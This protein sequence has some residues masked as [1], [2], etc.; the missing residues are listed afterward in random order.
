[1]FF[2]LAGRPPFADGSMVQKLLQ[3]QQEP[4]PAI[5][6]VRSDVPRSFAAIL[7]RLMEKNPA[8]RYQRPAE[9]VADLLA[10][11]D[12]HGHVV[13]AQRS[14]TATLEPSVP[15]R[16][17]ARLPWLVP[18]LGLTATI[19][20]LWYQAA[21][22]RFRTATEPLAVPADARPVTV[23]PTV[24]RV[25]ESR[26]TGGSSD[27]TVTAAEFAAALQKSSDGDVV[28]LAFDGVVDVPAFTLA[29]RRLTVRATPGRRPSL[30]FISLMDQDNGLAAAC[31][32]GTG[33]LAIEGV[34]L[35]MAADVP[36]GRRPVLFSL[37][38]G[39]LVCSDALLFMPTDPPG[40]AASESEAVPAFVVMQ[41]AE[42]DGMAEDEPNASLSLVRTRACGD[43]VF[44]DA[45]GLSGRISL[46]WSGGG[47]L[48]SRPLI[49]VDAAGGAVIEATL[50]D[51]VFACRDGLVSLR[52]SPSN[53][54]LPRLT[55]VATTCRFLLEDVPLV[56]QT[57]I[58]EP[59][60]YDAAFRWRD[61]GS[62]YEGSDVMRR[63]EGAAER[64]DSFFRDQSMAPRHAS[65]VASW[66]EAPA[67]EAA[68][69]AGSD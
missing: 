48:S 53:T 7:G 66:P 31:D 3:H 12:T 6:A 28:E 40:G 37:G 8:D 62:R 44:L 54:G 15:R 65:R 19:G 32:I 17:A 33:R 25:G 42:P 36:A 49:A 55:V 59:A 4:P 61:E 67:W 46:A 11:A 22:A 35:R 43:A 52:D 20:G 50:A 41:S 16:P 1:M 47:M 13:M 60:D 26:V 5:D 57:G 68:W 14:A 63:V 51:A 38:A 10:F 34:A 69:E 64:I 21:A 45:T 29:G 9:L 30:R 18:L 56:V 2:M 39:S 58:A 27:A 23:T 24:V